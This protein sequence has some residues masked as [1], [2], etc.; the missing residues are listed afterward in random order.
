MY[1]KIQPYRQLTISNQTFS[2]LSA[3][4]YGPYQIL[5]RI[6]PVAYKL[7]LPPQVAVHHTFHVSQLKPCLALPPNFNHPPTVDV[8]SPNCV[9]P[10]EIL[11]RRM[12]KRG[13]KAIP[14]ILIHWEQM[15]RDDATWEDYS[16]MK[17]RFPQFLS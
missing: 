11:E 17:L 7:S 16:T 4:Y 13:N 6:G 1:L 5:Q 12:I 8:S 9:Q 3:K 14:Q 2:K 10:Q 15:S